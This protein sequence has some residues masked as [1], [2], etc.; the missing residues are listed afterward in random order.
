MLSI[1]VGF[2]V[3]LFFLSKSHTPFPL[4]F[5]QEEKPSTMPIQ[6][7]TTV[8]PPVEER[9]A[10]TVGWWGLQTLLS[11]FKLLC[12]MSEKPLYIEVAGLTQLQQEPHTLL[13][14]QHFNSL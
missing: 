13:D 2:F 12:R 6:L 8:V 1:W 5:E 4:D 11:R 9:S 3:V 14:L 10:L 7:N